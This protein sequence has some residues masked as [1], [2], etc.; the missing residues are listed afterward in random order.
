MIIPSSNKTRLSSPIGIA[1]PSPKRPKLQVKLDK[2]Q[3]QVVFDYHLLF[4]HSTPD[5][6]MK[7]LKNPHLHFDP[8]NI[9]ASTH[10][11]MSCS[12]CRAAKLKT[13]PHFRK[14]HSYHPGEAISSDVVGP[15]NHNG[16]RLY[17]AYFVT[18]IDTASRYAICVPI[19]KRTEV[20]PFIEKCIAQFISIFNTPLLVFLS[21][22]TLKNTFRR[23]WMKS[24]TLS[25]Y[26]ICQRRPTLTKK[27]AER[28]NQTLFNTVR[29]ALYTA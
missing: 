14:H 16:Q 21:V 24:W 13:A 22:T 11:P 29:A 5:I 25:I 8:K 6:I 23:T 28:I 7:T 4:N 3:R 27:M 20:V 2:K 19:V 15:F 17:E 1:A 10:A 18:C 26:S 9:P 12:L